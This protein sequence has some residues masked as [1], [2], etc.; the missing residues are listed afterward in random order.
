M[1]VASIKPFANTSDILWLFMSELAKW[2]I[3]SFVDFNIDS[4]VY[5]FMIRVTD[6]VPATNILR[7]LSSNERVFVNDIIPDFKFTTEV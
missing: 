5:D 2:H 7:R 4:G 3:T 1:C 6:C